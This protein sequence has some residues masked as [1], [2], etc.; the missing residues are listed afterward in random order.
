VVVRG[1]RGGAPRTLRYDVLDRYDE[2]HGITAMM[3]TT[4]YSLA[5]T[6]LMQVDGRVRE[7][8]VHTPDEAVPADEY[9]RELARRGIEVVR[10]EDF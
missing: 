6:A 1:S 9:I 8:G 4:G 7:C 10:S 3:R 2:G 5:V